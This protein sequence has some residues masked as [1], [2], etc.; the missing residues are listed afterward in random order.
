V[1]RELAATL[2]YRL[3]IVDLLLYPVRIALGKFLVPPCLLL[4]LACT[5]K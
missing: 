5:L 3:E 1:S 2:L 4:C